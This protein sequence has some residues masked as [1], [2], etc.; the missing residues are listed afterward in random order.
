MKKISALLLAAALFLIP[1]MD[2]F[3][4]EDT[5]LTIKD[6]LERALPPEEGRK[7]V[8]NE[9]AKLLTVMDTKTNHKLIKQLIEQFE[10]GQKQVMIEARFV[11]V[12]V[13]DLAELGIEWDFYT[14]A[15]GVTADP[16]IEWQSRKFF[17]KPTVNSAGATPG[18]NPEYQGIHWNDDA[19]TAFPKV[20]N[21][22]G[23]LLIQKI[24]TAGDFLTA[25]LRALEQLGK[26][27]LLSAPKVTTVSGQMA[28]IQ[29]T[30]TYPYVSDF[31]LENI[32]TAGDP[33]WSYKL[34]ISEKP[35]GISLEVTPYVGEGTNTITLDLHPE[36]SVLKKQVVISNLRAIGT[37]GS[38]I[39]AASISVGG[40]FAAQNTTG[41][42]AGV[43]L[44][45]SELGWPV[46]DT[47][48]TQTS[49]AIDSGETIVLGGM[50]KED[51]RITKRKVP[52]FGD[53][54]LLGKAF[55]YQ[56]KSV[57]KR[58]LLIFITASIV[59][60]DGEIIR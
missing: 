22:A 40:G 42:T 57:E 30:R 27:N 10:I 38:D 28:N 36:V 20:G 8:Y 7:V 34:T 21:L 50:I 25:N 53:I 32:G 24:T 35:V 56:Y 37:T 60:A 51:E 55:Q 2:V 26:A 59:T 15:H 47:R 46:V 33:I 44:I 13:T 43:P 14:N 16:N 9:Q 49:V 41:S 5:Q 4:Q 54:P 3:S 23:Q 12:D 18:Y 6:Y 48:T 29:S 45:D 19:A 1:R 39:S 31:T 17:N 58:E 52:F 11:E